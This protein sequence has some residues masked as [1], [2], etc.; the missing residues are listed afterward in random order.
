[1]KP[2]NIILLGFVNK[3]ADYLEKH[4]DEN[5]NM[6]LNETDRINFESLRKELNKNLDASLG[7]MKE[8]ATKLLQA[9]YDAFDKFINSQEN[10][11]LADEIDRL[12]DVNFDLNEQSSEDDIA[13]LLDYYQLNDNLTEEDNNLDTAENTEENSFEMPDEA[14]ELLKIISDNV[15]K[16]NDNTSERQELVENNGVYSNDDNFDSIYSKLVDDDGQPD[17]IKFTNPGLNHQEVDFL[18]DE[19]RSDEPAINNQNYEVFNNLI[20][21]SGAL[22]SVISDAPV[23]QPDQNDIVEFVKVMQE[24]DKQYYEHILQQEPEYEEVVEPEPEQEPRQFGINNSLLDDLK[25]KM[26]EEDERNR[27]LEQEFQSVYDKIHEIY[28]YLEKDFVRN[29]YRMKDS[30]TQEYPLD[31]KVI[32]LHRIHFKDVENLR[33]FV[34]IALNHNYSINADENKLIVDVFKQHINADGKIMTSI[35]EVANQSVLLNAEY[36]GYRVLYEENE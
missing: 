22:H 11:S 15:N 27:K 6:L 8:T 33:Q 31:V 35:F 26:N 36:E 23:E 9:G 25:R 30:I 18:K 7:N 10:T 21:D 14:Q 5:P 32:I 16:N 29:I 4:F 24:S 12:F 1:M 13:K 17:F 20:D 3:A 2:E 34:E 19:H 28:P